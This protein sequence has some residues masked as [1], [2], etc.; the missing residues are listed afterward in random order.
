MKKTPPLLFVLLTLAVLV[1]EANER[2]QAESQ[3]GVD[4]QRYADWSIEG[5]RPGMSLNEA[6]AEWGLLTLAYRVDFFGT[7][8]SLFLRL[9][10]DGSTTPG[11]IVVNKQNLVTQVQGSA[12]E[13]DGS[14]LTDLPFTDDDVLAVV[15]N[16]C[17]ATDILVHQH[18]ILLKEHPVSI[19]GSVAPQAILGEDSEWMALCY[20]TDNLGICLE[21]LDHVSS[22]IPEARR[23]LGHYARSLEEL[24]E[25][26][27][28]RGLMTVLVCPV[29]GTY[30]LNGPTLT[31]YSHPKGPISVTRTEKTVKF[32]RGAPQS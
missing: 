28:D 29:G 9:R 32:W 11:Y 8:S 30:Q 20:R 31:C 4:F 24:P 7:E 2:L 15:G 12:L 22:L 17:R 16:R 10:E 19:R 21:G 1:R 27:K 25:Y 18:K 6:R 5:V 13:E 26:R 14:A 3:G 23:R